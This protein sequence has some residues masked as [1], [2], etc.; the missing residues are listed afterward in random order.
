MFVLSILLLIAA[1]VVFLVGRGRDG[2]GWRLGAVLSAVG[3]ALA[4][5]FACVHVVSAYEVGVPVTFGKVGTPL[6]SGIQF[7]S[8]FT[9]VTSFS[10]RPVDLNL[11]DKDVVE[12]R[13]SQGGVLYADVTI[14]WAVVPAK[15][16]A[17]YRLA[18]SEEAVQERLVLPDSR[19]IIRNVFAKHTSEE[20]YAS[21]REQIG[22]EIEDL[23]KERL[24][25]RGIDVTAVNLRN[26]KP[27]DKL[28]DQI[29]KK[30]QQEQATERSEEGQRTAKAEA[31]RKRIEA[32]GIATANKIIEKSLSDK[33][34][35]NQCLE[36][37]K[38]AAK[39]NPVYAVPCGTDSGGTPVIVDNSKN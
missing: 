11:Y 18:G 12:V 3:G 21:A 23:I 32:E 22:S 7:K 31:E 6:T 8:P 26:V 15:A 30:I 9:D 28:Q 14:K 27:S 19:E 2:G 37:Y 1:V 5:V 33:V 38:E 16:V 24:T 25:P 34:L 10:T 29:D 20:G 36:A 39:A 17:L 4:G 35:Y 13:S